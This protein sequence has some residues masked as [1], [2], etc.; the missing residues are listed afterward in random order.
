M[1]PLIVSVLTI[2]A[3]GRKCPIPIVMVAEQIRDVGSSRVS[4]ISLIESSFV[5]SRIQA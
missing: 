4:P 1:P 3:L 2:D 5:P